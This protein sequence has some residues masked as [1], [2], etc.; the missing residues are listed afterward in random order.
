MK[1]V[2]LLPIGVMMFLALVTGCGKEPPPR[3]EIVF[4]G[5]PGTT[6]HLRDRVFHLSKGNLGLL[7]PGGNYLC[8]DCTEENREQIAE[9]LF[10]TAKNEYGTVPEFTLELIVLSGIL[11]WNYQI[12]IFVPQCPDRI[13][14]R[15][16]LPKM[17]KKPADGLFYSG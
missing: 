14:E 1:W 5:D 15:A 9:K 17:K 7:L 11:Q 16:C 3:A 12:Q 2:W 8:A 4:T 6:V 13:A 10:E